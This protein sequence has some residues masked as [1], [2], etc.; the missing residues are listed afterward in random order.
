MIE[1]P[2]LL[3]QRLALGRFLGSMMGFVSSLLCKLCS[4]FLLFIWIV[5]G[6]ANRD[7]QHETN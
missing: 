7:I 6:L 4:P 5:D 2:G 3:P 1:H